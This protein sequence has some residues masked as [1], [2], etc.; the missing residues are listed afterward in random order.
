[1]MHDSRSDFFSLYTNGSQIEA[2]GGNKQSQAEVNIIS[3]DCYPFFGP[4]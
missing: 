1:M 2:D 4:T 3:R